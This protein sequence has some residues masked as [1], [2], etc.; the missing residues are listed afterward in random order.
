[1]YVSR[2][3]ADTGKYPNQLLFQHEV[4]YLFQLIKTLLGGAIAGH[5]LWECLM[6]RIFVIHIDRSFSNSLPV[7]CD[8]QVLRHSAYLLGE[9]GEADG[10]NSSQ[11]LTLNFLCGLPEIQRT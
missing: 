6:N 4:F 7:I 1:M 9:G 10:N 2:L 8:S 3:S 5:S 11:C